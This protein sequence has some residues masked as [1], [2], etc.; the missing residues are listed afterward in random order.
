[1]LAL[2][3]ADKTI[4]LISC[5][6]N[7]TFLDIIC[8]MVSSLIILLLYLFGSDMESICDNNWWHST[9]YV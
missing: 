2:V 3:N 8:F 6:Y 1:M 7:T 5:P 9:E 4:N